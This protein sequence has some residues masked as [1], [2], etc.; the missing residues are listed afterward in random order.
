MTKEYLLWSVDPYEKNLL[1]HPEDVVRMVTGEYLI[2]IHNVN[3]DQ[4]HLDEKLRNFIEE[5]EQSDEDFYFNY[6]A[7]DIENF[8]HEIGFTNAETENANT[9]EE[10]RDQTVFNTYNNSFDNLENYDTVKVFEYW[11]GSNYENYY[12]DNNN[13]TETHVLTS[14]DYVSLDEWDGNNMVTGDTG[15]HQKVRKIYELDGEKVSDMYLVIYWSQWENEPTEAEIM[16]V[17][18]LRQHLQ[19]IERDVDE[20]IEEI[21]KIA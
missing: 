7:E 4:Q 17:D 2:L 21:Q 6:N 10:V 9:L 18:Q 15:R 16:D 3:A 11:N 19:E 5:K 8:L 12:L 1:V 20:Y 14:E 13:N